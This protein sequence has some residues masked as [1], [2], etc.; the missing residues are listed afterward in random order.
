M[1]KPVWW[2]NELDVCEEK[3]V[4]VR[5]H[6]QI[7][8]FPDDLTKCQLALERQAWISNTSGSENWIDGVEDLPPDLG[9]LFDEFH[10]IDRD[11]HNIY[12]APES[13]AN[14]FKS[15]HHFQGKI[16]WS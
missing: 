2:N 1:A 13:F 12:R 11:Q 16:V 14:D 15:Q 10:E 6:D 9:D 7:T 3:F 5:T 4:L 8:D